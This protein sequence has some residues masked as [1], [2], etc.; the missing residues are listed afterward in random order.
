VIGSHLQDDHEEITTSKNPLYSSQQ[1]K[2]NS[3]NVRWTE[4]SYLEVLL[5]GAYLYLFHLRIRM[6]NS[7]ERIIAWIAIRMHLWMIVFS[8]PVWPVVAF[9]LS[10]VYVRLYD[11]S[12]FRLSE[13][14]AYVEPTIVHVEVWKWK[15]LCNYPPD[16]DHRTMEHGV[17]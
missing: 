4:A 10:G 3:N 9:F 13:S 16:W 15:C 6:N 8:T 12:I 7:K 2:V 17:L 1:V 11:L 5:Y 14:L